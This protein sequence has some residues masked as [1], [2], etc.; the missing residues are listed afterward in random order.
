MGGHWSAV[1]VLLS[2]GANPNVK[3][4]AGMAAIH[5]AAF[6]NKPQFIDLLLQN[7]AEID[8]D[9]NRLRTPLMVAANS[10]ALGAVHILLARGAN[11]NLKDCKGQ[12]AADHAKRENHDFAVEL[13]LG[14]TVRVETEISDKKLEHETAIAGIKTTKFDN[15]ILFLIEM[16][17]D[18]KF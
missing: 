7:G 14:K 5:H 1:E 6:Q 11:R 2:F 12:T 8:A 18:L 4:E 16:Y 17:F 9:E 13:L 3:T 15:E 10:G